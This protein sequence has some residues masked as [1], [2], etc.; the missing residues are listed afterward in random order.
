[1]QSA[2]RYRCLYILYPNSSKSFSLFSTITSSIMTHYFIHTSD[3]W[4]AVAC[5]YDTHQC[6]VYNVLCYFYNCRSCRDH[7]MNDDTIAIHTS[8]FNIPLSCC[9]Y[10]EHLSRLASFLRSMQQILTQHV[11]WWWLHCSRWC[12]GSSTNTAHGY[13]CQSYS[14]EWDAQQWQ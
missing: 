2:S 10:P 13:Q 3:S 6:C 11:R 1:M 5:Y 7:R 4:S 8:L 9:Y 12:G 14:L